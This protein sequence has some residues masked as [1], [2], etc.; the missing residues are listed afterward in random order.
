MGPMGW[1]F[2]GSEPPW[3]RVSGFVATE[4]I[5]KTETVLIPIMKVY[6]ST[7]ENFMA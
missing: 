1:N 3:V 7:N 5:L 4:R 6:L 2:F